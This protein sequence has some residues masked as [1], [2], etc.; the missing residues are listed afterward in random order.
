MGYMNFFNKIHKNTVLKAL[1]LALILNLIAI[2]ADTLDYPHSGA[3]IIT[4]DSC[5]FIY[6]GE[7]SLLPPWTAHIP[8]DI[9]DTQYNML[10][11]SCH[12][13]LDYPFVRS[14]SS[15]STDNGYGDWSV[16]CRTC[17]NPHKQEQFKTYGSASYL[18]E[19]AVSSVSSTTLTETGAGWTPDEYVGLILVPNVAKVSY[20]YQIT[21]NTS[22]T[23]TVKGTIDTARVGAGNT[24]AIVY[25]KLVKSTITTPNSGDSAVKFFNET[26][27]NSFADGD[28]MYNGICEVCHIQTTYHDDIGSGASHNEGTDCTQC[29]DH[30]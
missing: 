24:F 3:N 2:Q 8:Q 21:G 18:Y 7:P 15:L 16:E 19:G 1:I 4:C 27:T 11:W 6:G 12:N 20:N 23:L 26:G 14:H 30:L 17:H 9:D 13:G 25:G 28:I 5:H 29:H 10:C 22:D